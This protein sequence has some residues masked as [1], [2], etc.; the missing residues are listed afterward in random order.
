MVQPNAHLIIENELLGLKRSSKQTL[1]NRRKLK[2]I[3]TLY[4]HRLWN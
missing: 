1:S 2:E 3:N 4:G